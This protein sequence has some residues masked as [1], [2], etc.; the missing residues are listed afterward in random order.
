MYIL[1]AG[2][3]TTWQVE[4]SRSEEEFPFHEKIPPG[5]VKGAPDISRKAAGLQMG[6][7]RQEEV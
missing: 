2:G 4:W 5:E 7:G 6:P 3:N 1:R